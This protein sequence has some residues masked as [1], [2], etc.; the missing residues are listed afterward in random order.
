MLYLAIDDLL[1]FRCVVNDVRIEK[2]LKAEACSKHSTTVNH[3]QHN[4]IEMVYIL[5]V[6]YNNVYYI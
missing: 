6:N 3:I 2:N 5:K 4:L 1:K